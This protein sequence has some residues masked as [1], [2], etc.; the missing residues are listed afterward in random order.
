MKIARVEGVASLW[1]GL[2]PTLL[3]AVPTT[4]V[5]FTCYEQL[6][7]KIAYEYLLY[8]LSCTADGEWFANLC[9][10]I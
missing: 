2:P 6:R 10:L 7:R 5:Y 3:M 1:S 9:G 4:V 8:K